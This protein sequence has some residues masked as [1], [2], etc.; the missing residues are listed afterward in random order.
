VS[1]LGSAADRP[2]PTWPL[3]AAGAA[4]A[5]IVGLGVGDPSPDHIV[6]LAALVG[7]AVLLM[8][9]IWPGRG[10]LVLVGSSVMV[11]AV[12][13]ADGAVTVMP[14]DVLLLPLL[15]ITALTG[16]IGGTAEVRRLERGPS[17]DMLRR[18]TK[19]FTDSIWLYVLLA[20]AS[21]G[22]TV[23]LGQPAGALNSLNKLFRA[24]EGMSMFGIGVAWMSGRRDLRL[25]IKAF[26]VGVLTFAVVNGIALV[27]AP[28]TSDNVLRRAGMI[29]YVNE[30][31]W[32][33]ASANEAGIGL[34][35]VWA[36]LLV[37][38]RWRPRPYGWVLLGLTLAMLLLSQSRSGLLAWL[39]FTAMTWREV[40]RA[41]VVVAGIAL[42]LAAPFVT[43]V[44]WSRMSHTLFAERGSFEVYSSLIRVY[45]WQA[46]WRMFLD[47][48]WFGV[49]Y[50]GF[51]HFADR[52]NDLGLRLP[53]AESIF[54]ET[55]T[56]MGVV[57]LF[58][59]L[60]AVGRTFALG[61]AVGASS[62]PGSLGA[63][64]ARFHTPFIVASLV[65]NLTGDNWVGLV[66]LAQTACWCALLVRAGHLS[67]DGPDALDAA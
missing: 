46:A 41:A 44:W 9:A 10:Y 16:S 15:A 37:S 6:W 39:V 63:T 11:I 8:T 67:V 22:I 28:I 66:G 47:H 36:V 52:Y 34:V 45:G 12:S 43:T 35:L 33:I 56:G 31:D 4:I 55:A 24:V 20:L 48:P 5:L 26:M 32:S 61:R 2:Y 17:H 42:A 14:F 51:R 50:L 57:G 58:V 30:S 21:L 27:L 65:S 62:R 19:R 64:M 59:F 29:W 38:Q 1:S 53:T 23:A 54:F 7:T 40:P 60:R 25:M 3:W 18:A 13:I 49:G